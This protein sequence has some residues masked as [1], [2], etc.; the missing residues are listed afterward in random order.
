M[1][2]ECA[3]DVFRR[4]ALVD[5]D[6]LGADV[7]RVAAER[8]DRDLDRRSGPGRR[9]QEERG[10]GPALEQRRNR[11]RA[12]FP[13]DGAVEDCSQAGRVEVVDLEEL[14]R[15]DPTSAGAAA[16][17]VARIATAAS[18]SSS[19]HEQRRREPQRARRHRVDDQ[20]RVE[21]TLRDD[22]GVDAV[23]ELHREQ[24]AE[25][26][27]GSDT[28]ERLQRGTELGAGSLRALRAPAPVP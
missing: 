26:A 11:A 8:R 27:H 13:F 24:Q 25:A 4:L 5:S 9:L 23:R 18:I 22:L 6:L 1:R 15:H 20:A 3:G 14:G 17:T 16:S 10:H 21:A 2:R 28:G 7:D 12:R 19:S